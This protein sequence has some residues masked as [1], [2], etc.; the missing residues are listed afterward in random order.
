MWTLFIVLVAIAISP[1]LGLVASMRPRMMTTARVHLGQQ[2]STPSGWRLAMGEVYFE[3]NCE[4]RLKDK[5]GRC[6]GMPGYQPTV[7]EDSV[8]SGSFADFQKASCYLSL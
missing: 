2:R 6:P 1:A 5:N 3:N 4:D 7:P 8:P